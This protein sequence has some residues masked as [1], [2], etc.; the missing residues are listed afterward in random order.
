MSSSFCIHTHIVHSSRHTGT[1]LDN[2]TYA[3]TTSPPVQ[4]AHYSSLGPRDTPTTGHAHPQRWRY[5]RV[6]DGEYQEISQGGVYHV[7]GEN[8]GQGRDEGVSEMGYST[9][10]HN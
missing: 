6:R 4:Y 3:S 2:P 10:Q 5:G 9:L 8:N 1:T 7:L